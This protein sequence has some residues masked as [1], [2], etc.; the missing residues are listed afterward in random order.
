ML[1][2][3]SAML[4]ASAME[5][6]KT[7]LELQKPSTPAAVRLGAARATLDLGMKIRQTVELEERVDELEQIL[8]DR[9]KLHPSWNQ[10]K[11]V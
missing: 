8:T 3:A 6:I 1:E 9:K 11:A 10:R 7:L 2:R 4:T 5:A